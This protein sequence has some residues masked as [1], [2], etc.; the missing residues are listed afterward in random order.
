MNIG[1]GRDGPGAKDGGRGD[2]CKI[3]STPDRTPTESTPAFFNGIG[4]RP[5]GQVTLSHAGNG[6]SAISR[7]LV[8][9]SGWELERGFRVRATIVSSPDGGIRRR[10]AEGVLFG[11]DE[12]QFH[13]GDGEDPGFS[14]VREPQGGPGGSGPGSAAVRFVLTDDPDA[15]ELTD[16]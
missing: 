9:D 1:H 16:G 4:R 10:W 2:P 7:R 14:G 8:W 15:L 6:D 13:E 11:P 12:D 3:T 5:F